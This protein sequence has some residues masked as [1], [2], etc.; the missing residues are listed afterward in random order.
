MK[1]PDVEAVGC[2]MSC[3]LAVV[4]ALVVLWAIVK[5]VIYWT[6]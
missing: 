4:A 2:S 3:G 5:L 6:S 1:K